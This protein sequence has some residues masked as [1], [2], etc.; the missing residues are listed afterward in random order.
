ME[1]RARRAV[2]RVR[3]EADQTGS[4]SARAASA[5]GPGECVSALTS[6]SSGTCRISVSVASSAPPA[7]PCRGP[8]VSACARLMSHDYRS[9]NVRRNLRISRARERCRY[10][11]DGCHD[12]RSAPG[13]P[14]QEAVADHRGRLH[15]S[16]PGRPARDRAA[17]QGVRGD[18][19]PVRR[20]EPADQH[21]C[22]R[23]PTRRGARPQLRGAARQRGGDARRRGVARASDGRLRPGGQG[24][25][26][27]AHRH[28]P[29]RDLG[30]R[31]RLPNAPSRWRTRTRRR[32]WRRSARPPQRRRR[33]RFAT[34]ANGS[35]ISRGSWSRSTPAGAS[36]T[37]ANARRSRVSSP[38]RATHGRRAGERGPSG[39]QCLHRQLGRD[40]EHPGPAAHEAL[41]AARRRARRAARSRRGPPAQQLRQAPAQRGGARGAR[42]GADHREDSA[43]AGR[44]GPRG[45][46]ARGVPVPAHQPAAGNEEPRRRDRRDERVA[47]G[48]Q[49]ERGAR[50]S[51]GRRRGRRPRDR[52]GLRLPRPML[53][54]TFGV[55]GRAGVT[56]VSWSGL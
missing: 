45:G 25:L 47:G 38:P 20:R 1:A 40:T 10:S 4:P 23:R 34:C 7:V 46:R 12:P 41:R 49:D 44:L 29:D 36:R 5:T 56:N 32:S 21:R 14:A 55:D 37:S 27:G 13:C 54:P 2:G 42:G 48:G 18:R 8:P 39:E 52:R 26:R 11:G 22:E 43:A 31:R 35:R 51:P 28:A 6:T 17:P 3:A 9:M 33:A 16:L 24:Q 19:H 15:G 53:A 30:A 50:A